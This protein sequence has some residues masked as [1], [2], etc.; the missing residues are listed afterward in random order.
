MWLGG[1]RGMGAD[2]QQGTAEAA[3]QRVWLAA[4][5]GLLADLKYQSWY[6]ISKIRHCLSVTSYV[7]FAYALSTMT[8]ILDLLIVRNC[9]QP[10]TLPCCFRCPLLPIRTHS[11][12]STSQLTHFDVTP[13]MW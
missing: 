2:R 12:L 11:P 1:W 6:V 3:W 13:F 4:F 9:S 5:A 8:G 10:D 7:D